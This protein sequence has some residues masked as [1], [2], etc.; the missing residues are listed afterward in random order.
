MRDEMITVNQEI[1][2]EGRYER[3][4]SKARR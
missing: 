4:F 1:V 3:G 2:D